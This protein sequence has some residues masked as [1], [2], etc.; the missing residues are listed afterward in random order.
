VA[1]RYGVWV[2]KSNYGRTYMGI[3]RT[4]F[5]LDED[6]RIAHVFENVKAA[7]HE[8]EVLAWLSH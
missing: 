7:G 2:P 1:E 6:G 5:I 3:A 8:Q 4:T